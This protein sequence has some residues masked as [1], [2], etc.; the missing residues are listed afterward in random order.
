[1]FV[2][3]IDVKHNIFKDKDWRIMIEAIIIQPYK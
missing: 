1:M 3:L 2:N